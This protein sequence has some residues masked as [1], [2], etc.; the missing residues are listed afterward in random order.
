MILSETLN[1]LS[2]E[3][4]SLLY[5]IGNEIFLPL[6]INVNN[7][8][9]KGLKVHMVIPLIENFKNNAL[10]DKKIIFDSLKEKISN[11]I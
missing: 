4:L 10:E 5:F 3:E 6:G 11:Q 7:D 2:E 1:K 9:L 8:L